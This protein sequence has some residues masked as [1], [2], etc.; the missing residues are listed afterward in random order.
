[1]TKAELIEVVNK[2]LRTINKERKDDNNIFKYSFE[3]G[4]SCKITKMLELYE[5]ITEEKEVIDLCEELYYE[6]TNF[7][8][9]NKSMKNAIIP[10]T[11]SLQLIGKYLGFNTTVASHIE[12]KKM[13]YELLAEITEAHYNLQ[14]LCEDVQLDMSNEFEKYNI[15]TLILGLFNTYKEIDKIRNENY[16]K[17]RIVKLKRL[18]EIL[19]NTKQSIITN[20]DKIIEED[21]QRIY[22][23]IR[24]HIQANTKA[25]DIDIEVIF[26]KLAEITIMLK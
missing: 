6:M 17:Q 13:R 19:N 14:E 9:L 12:Y 11:Y 7:N 25:S 4:I 15:D 24:A 26:R 10:I 1:M 23:D 2:E 22:L 20:Y 21:A 18:D 8:N 16:S 3:D 5:S